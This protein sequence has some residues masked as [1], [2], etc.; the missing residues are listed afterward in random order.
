M[1]AETE[2]YAPVKQ[3]LERQGFRV[4][5]EVNSCDVVGMRDGEVVIV[6]LKRVFNLELVFQ[7]I[8]RKSLSETVYAA[9]AAASIKKRS[10]WRKITKLCRL[11]GLGLL[12]VRENRAN[13]VDVA[14]SPAPYTPRLNTAKRRALVR[15]FQNRSADYNVG[16]CTRKKI[17]TAYRELALRLAWQMQSGPRTVGDLADAGPKG[18]AG[19]ILFKNFY[20]WFERVDRGVYQLT[21]DGV[22]ALRV[23]AE[24]VRGFSPPADAAAGPAAATPT[25]QATRRKSTAARRSRPRPRAQKKAA[26]AAT[27]TPASTPQ[28]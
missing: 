23:Y 9:V 26:Q 5:G 22:D 3:F 16:G 8:S 12:T 4:A 24:V 27:Q 25:P 10:Q 28:T 1:T 20:G 2:L 21:P 6:E 18:K 19:Q 11:L 14:L 15:E 13:A 7:A 17:V